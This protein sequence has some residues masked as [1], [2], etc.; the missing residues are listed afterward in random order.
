MHSTTKVHPRVLAV[1][2]MVAT[3]GAL[4]AGCGSSGSGS[5]STTAAAKTLPTLTVAVDSDEVTPIPNGIIQL[6]VQTGAFKKAGV[7]VKLVSLE[8]TPQVVQALVAGRADVANVDTSDAIDL[9]AKKLVDAKAFVSNGAS[10][11]Y[12]VVA[13]DS[14]GSFAKV[15]GA[16]FANETPGSEPDL[17]MKLLLSQHQLPASAVSNVSIGSPA[18]RLLAVVKGRAGITIVSDSQ[19]ESL[20]KAQASCCHLLYNEQQFLTAVPVEA[21]L[22]IASQAALK[23]KQPALKAFIKAV[24][25]MSRQYDKDPSR[26]AA[27]VV[28]TRTDL[29]QPTLAAHA[30]GPGF[31][32]QWCLNGCMNSQVLSSTSSFFYKSS[33]LAGVPRIPLSDWVDTTLLKQVLKQMGVASG[34]DKP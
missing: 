25:T 17:M 15:K 26:W 28:K 9:A 2:M 10:P 24:L 34:P 23:H 27:Q 7:D 11:D 6:G 21:K 31:A 12:V 30:A 3:A 1:A 33:A 16:T 4:I 5:G 20:T 19:W 22:D 32:D 13:S 14:I 18:D 8:G 29:Q